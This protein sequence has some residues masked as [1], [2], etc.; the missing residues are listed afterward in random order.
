MLNFSIESTT[1]D[2]TDS[3]L[4]L[5]LT[6]ENR[7]R[8]PVNGHLFCSTFPL[9]PPPLKK[10]SQTERETEEK[11]KIGSKKGMARHASLH[12]FPSQTVCLPCT[13]LSPSSPFFQT[14]G[15]HHHSRPLLSLSSSITHPC[16]VSIHCCAQ[17]RPSSLPLPHHIITLSNFS[18]STSTSRP[19]R[20]VKLLSRQFFLFFWVFFFSIARKVAIGPE[21]PLD[22]VKALIH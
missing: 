20:S 10:K 8:Q 21:Q 9:A 4:A 16:L 13:V 7:T 14:H 17:S 11:K 12:R 5:C 1:T 15:L 18:S 22:V 19:T 6:L 2:M 3:T